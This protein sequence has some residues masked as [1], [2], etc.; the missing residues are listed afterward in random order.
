MKTI[1]L[2]GGFGTRLSEETSLRPKPMVEIGGRPI[3]THI[4]GMYS[5]YGF[6][7]FLVAGGYKADF[8][9]N[10]FANLPMQLNDFEIDLGSG[11]VSILGTNSPDWKVAVVDTG[12]Q[13]MTGGR[14]KRLKPHTNGTFMCTYGDGVADIDIKALVDFHKSHGKLATIT[15][16]RPPARFGSL[17]MDGEKVTE[18]EEKNPLKEGWINGGFFVLEPEVFNYID[19]DSQPFEREPLT[20]IAED[21]QLMAYKHSGFWQPMDTLREKNM[22]DKIVNEGKAPWM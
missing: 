17:I 4:M 10:Y 6:N 5:K 12:L 21:G 9:K 1:L 18:F 14:I 7:E 16:V 3:L 8:I 22:L 2:A 13:T 11:D 15:A 19:D 20:R